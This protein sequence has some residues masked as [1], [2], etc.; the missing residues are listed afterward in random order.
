[1]KDCYLQIVVAVLED[2][3]ALDLQMLDRYLED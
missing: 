2:F 3:V 1:M